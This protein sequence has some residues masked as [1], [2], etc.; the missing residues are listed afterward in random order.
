MHIRTLTKSV[1]ASAASGT[2]VLQYISAILGIIAQL[3]T[4][5]GDV[6]ANVGTFSA[7]S[8]S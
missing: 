5:V 1:P 7:K 3:N 2:T 8:G 4:L 6:A